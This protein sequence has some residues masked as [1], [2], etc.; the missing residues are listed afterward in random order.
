MN[1]EERRQEEIA[2]NPKCQRIRIENRH[3]TAEAL[4]REEK[5]NPTADLRG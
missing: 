4:R 1:A 5:Q 3:L 2:R